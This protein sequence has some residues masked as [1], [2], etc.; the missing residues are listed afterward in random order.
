MVLTLFRKILFNGR[1]LDQVRH[2]RNNK[3]SWN[4]LRMFPTNHRRL[5]GLVASHG[6]FYASS[7]AVL[8]TS[9][10]TAGQ[11]EIKVVFKKDGKIYEVYGKEGDTLLDVIINNE[12]DFDGFGACEGTL[13]CSTCHVV[14]KKED[15]DRIPNKPCDEELDMLDLAYDLTDTSRLGC[16][17]QISKSLEGLEVLIPDTRHDA[18]S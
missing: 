10:K 6:R 11:N 17:I 8:A 12:L 7:S 3:G 18:R 9:P 15:Y 1:L 13:A 4:F 14:L 16:Q 2:V 5:Y